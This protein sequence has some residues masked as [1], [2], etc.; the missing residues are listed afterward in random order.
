MNGNDPEW[1]LTITSCIVYNQ[2]FITLY[3]DVCNI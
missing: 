3:Y 2:I 1:I